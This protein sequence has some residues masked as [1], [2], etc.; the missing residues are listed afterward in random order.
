MG[1]HVHNCI[2][3]FF[4]SRRDTL[5]PHASNAQGGPL[6]KR[7][8][9]VRT[10]RTPPAY[11]LEKCTLPWMNKFIQTKIKKRNSAYKRAKQTRVFDGYK[12]LRNEVVNLLRISK[13]DYLRKSC[14]GGSKKFWKAVKH[15]KNSSNHAIPAL[16]V[17]STVASSNVEKATL[18]NLTL[19]TNFNHS[20]HPLS[21]SNIHIFQANPSSPTSDEVLCV[22]DDIFCL[23]NTIDVTKASRPDGIS[24]YMLKGTAEAITPTVTHLFNLSLKSGKV[25]EAW[26]T[27]SVVPIPKTHR[28]SD[29]PIDY[30]PI[31]LLSTVSKLLEKHV[32]KLLW[33]HLNANGLVSDSQW[34]FCPSRSTVTALLSTFHAIFQLLEKGSDVCLIFFDLRK[35]FDS[36][37]HAPLLQ[38]LKDIGLNS[39]ILQ[40]ISSYLCCRK[41]YVVVE[42]TSSSTTSV[43]SGVPQGSVLGPLLFLTYINCVADLGFSDGTLISMYADD[44]L[45]WKPIKCS[46]DYVYLQTDINNIST[47][48]KSLYLS[49][50]SSKCKYIIASRKRQPTL[51]SSGLHLNGEALEH[52][53]SYRYLGILVTETLTW[54]EH[55][56]QV[57]SKAR[58][59]IGM[60]YRQFYFWTNT[61]VLRSIY[62]TCIRPHLEYAAQLWDPHVKRDIQMLESVQ[63]F[64]CKV[65][66]KCWD[67]DY[68]NMLHCLDLP[69][70]R[71][72]RQ[73]LKLI[74]MFNIVNGNIVFP[75]GIFNLH[76]HLSQRNNS[77]VFHKLHSR[78]NYFYFSYVP[79]VITVWNTLPVDI[80]SSSS[81]SVFKHNLL[82]WAHVLY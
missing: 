4:E 20:V 26:K 36:V 10:L 33:Q 74:T 48:I 9:C 47:C 46:N 57:C 40:W 70:L 60:M 51:P 13:R 61:S 68:D 54:S 35:A 23:L 11:G 44:I 18:L 41:K 38:H 63:K 53:R 43:P 29:N 65:C 64:A 31:S 3:Q 79:S 82:H 55:I 67:M 30:R 75:A 80:R 15:I 27:S 73:H 25:P 78:T 81:V 12:K 6:C 22:E 66:L 77:S 8:G 52:V 24:G 19:A 76:Q 69:L 49:L 62:I 45:L 5:A 34:G 21:P 28:P 56:Q 72:R 42:G 37:P 1:K 39:H 32:Y 2:T 17:K 58:K 59:L 50:N 71:V 14:L 16:R 7:G